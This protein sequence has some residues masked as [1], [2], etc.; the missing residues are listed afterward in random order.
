MH[1]R[2]GKNWFSSSLSIGSQV[3]VGNFSNRQSQEERGLDY[4]GIPP[5]PYIERHGERGPVAEHTAAL[6][7]PS[8]IKDYDSILQEHE[9]IKDNPERVLRRKGTRRSQNLNPEEKYKAD[10]MIERLKLLQLEADRMVKERNDRSLEENKV[11]DSIKRMEIGNKALNEEMLKRKAM[12]KLRKDEER[13]IKILEQRRLEEGEQKKR[14]EM[15]NRSRFEKLPTVTGLPILSELEN[16]FLPTLRC[17][18][19]KLS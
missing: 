8:F 3:T 12:L 5:D 10:N 14:L 9:G 13:V 4:A 18:N 19:A 11:A 1:R 17:T 6:R 16:Q 2:V 7:T 15:I